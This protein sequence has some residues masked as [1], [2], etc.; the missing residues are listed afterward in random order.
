MK[1]LEKT[2]LMNENIIEFITKQ[3]SASIC[4]MDVKGAPYCFSCFYAFN[5]NDGLLYFKSSAD[6][7]HIKRMLE[8]PIIA[9]TILPDKL[10]IVN[11]KGIQFQGNLLPLN[12]ELSVKAMGNYYKTHK[13][14]L[15]IPGIVWTVELNQIKMTD[16]SM[17]F[18]KKTNWQRNMLAVV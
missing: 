10:W 15:A 16:S 13:L 8:N 3:K 5:A 1:H 2:T 11:I 6:T 9:G 12:H 14:A 17:G 4:C 18:G 7:Y